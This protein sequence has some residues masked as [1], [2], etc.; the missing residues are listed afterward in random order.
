MKGFVDGVQDGMTAAATRPI[1]D[2]ELVR[3]LLGVL[4]AEERE[5]LEERSI[6]DEEIAERLVGLEQ[7]LVDG[8]AAGTLTGE[9]LRDFELFYLASPRRQRKAA[10]AHGLRRAIQ[11]SIR[12]AT[13]SAK[14][15][16]HQSRGSPHVRTWEFVAAVALVLA[17]ATL[18]IQNVVLR[19]ELRDI[20]RTAAAA[21][22][23]ASR[24]AEQLAAEQKATIAARQALSDTRA[25]EPGATGAFVLLPPTRGATSIPTISVTPGSPVVMLNLSLQTASDN[26]YDV[27]L[28]DPG[29]NRTVWRSQPLTPQRGRDTPVVVPAVPTGFL[30]PQPYTLDL[31]ELR[32]ARA[33]ELVASYAFKVTRQ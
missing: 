19:R 28:R 11:R 2:D 18:L 13:E 23:R 22:E 21:N 1:S 10:F 33:P 9:R 15:Q 16:P 27:A 30:K 5:R 7:D 6:V 14:A 26:T 25:A 29:T 17:I 12:K 32:P 31:F 4:P 24:A 3:Y 20:A 8:Y